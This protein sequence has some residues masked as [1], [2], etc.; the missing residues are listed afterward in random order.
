[1]VDAWQL[2]EGL[3]SA[4]DLFVAELSLPDLKMERLGQGA[5]DFY[6]H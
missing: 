1:L 4:R 2:R 6:R 3:F 5:R